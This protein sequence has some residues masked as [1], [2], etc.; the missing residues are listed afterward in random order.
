MK[1][2][3]DYSI[4]V[5]WDEFIINLP[6]SNAASLGSDVEREKFCEVNIVSVS[7]GY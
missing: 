2:K 7:C 6:A 3:A 1:L 5:I 4:W